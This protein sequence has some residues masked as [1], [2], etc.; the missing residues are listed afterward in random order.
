MFNNSQNKIFFIIGFLFFLISGCSIISTNK[1]PHKTE[2]K[3]ECVNQSDCGANEICNAEL[4]SCSTISSFS[5]E[6][7]VEVIPPDTETESYLLRKILINNINDLDVSSV[8]ILANNPVAVEGDITYV[9]CDNNSSG[10]KNCN[11]TAIPATIEFK[12]TTRTAYTPTYNVKTTDSNYFVNI[13]EGIYNI[14]ITPQDEWSSFLPPYYENN[15]TI[16]T[17]KN[18]KTLSFEYQKDAL[19][20]IKS[21]FIFLGDTSNL[22]FIVTAFDEDTGSRISNISTIDCTTETE[23]GDFELVIKKDINR[24]GLKITPIDESGTGVPTLPAFEIHGFMFDNLDTNDDSSISSSEFDQD[25]FSIPRIGNIYVISG[26]ILGDDNVPVKNATINFDAQELTISYSG[27]FILTN[28]VATDDNGEFIIP[29]IEGLYDVSII[30][31]VDSLYGN[32]KQVLDI[33][34][35]DDSEIDITYNLPSRVNLE[36][37]VVGNLNKIPLANIEINAIDLINGLT[38]SSITDER[39]YFDFHLD[40]GND[41]L[42]SIK[43]PQDYIYPWYV[44]QF[45]MTNSYSSS[46]EFDLAVPLIVKGYF[47]YENDDSY[48]YGETSII[49]IYYPVSDNDNNIKLIQIG[50]S[51]IDNLDGTFN[52]IIP[53]VINL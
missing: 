19:G 41:Y 34:N 51:K 16:G 48:N 20:Y 45:K 30:T 28:Q 27:Q 25:Y 23:C 22:K 32:S 44:T 26:R 17:N 3:N 50:Q 37:N 40:Y 13:P 8:D 9:E 24:F 39:G 49:N 38:F 1:N 52:L 29:L 42:L 33:R 46:V 5:E 21:Y 36:G 47:V 14:T 2:G 53:P 10:Q 11:E 31:S 12:S 4:N 43:T 18:G 6:I 15:V 7:Y 35:S